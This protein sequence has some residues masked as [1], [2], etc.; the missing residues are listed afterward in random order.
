LAPPVIPAPLSF[1]RFL[2]GPDCQRIL[3]EFIF[4]CFYW[5]DPFVL[6]LSCPFG[7]VFF[8]GYHG[9]ST[10]AFGFFLPFV[11]FLPAGQR[12]FDPPCFQYGV[13]GGL[14]QYPSVLSDPDPSFPLSVDFSSSTPLLL[15][16]DQYD[17]PL[18]SALTECGS[19]F[20]QPVFFDLL[21]CRPPHLLSLPFPVLSLF[22]PLA[23]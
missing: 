9:S 2:E 12:G 7:S 3:L 13:S 8:S 15:L 19:S 4:L 21:W 14:A 18:F 11:L 6:V 1:F 16:K 17:I 22:F 20:P 23:P 5:T 10:A